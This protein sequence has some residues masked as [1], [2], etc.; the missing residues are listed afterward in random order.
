MEAIF[1]SA[2]VTGAGVTAEHC[3]RRG[4]H[5]RAR[6]IS[7]PVEPNQRI[8]DSVDGEFLFA[9]RGRGKRQARKPQMNE[10]VRQ[11]QAARVRHHHRDLPIREAWLLLPTTRESGDR[12][13]QK[14]KT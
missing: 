7:L 9:P 5:A 1:L 4:I 10:F 3:R 8:R 14:S 13:L 12:H 2:G 6:H 11:S